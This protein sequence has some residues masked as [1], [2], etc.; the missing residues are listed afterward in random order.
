M[1]TKRIVEFVRKRDYVFIKELGQGGC[2][3]TVL[4]QDDVLDE[5]FVCKKYS[6]FYEQHKHELFDNFVREIKLLHEV[7]HQNVVRIFN[8]YLYPEKFTGYIVMEYIQGKDIEEY[9]EINPDRI[10]DVFLQTI[11]GFAHLEAKDI[12]HRD[13]R[14]MNILVRDDGVVKVIDLGFGKRV[15]Q[16]IDFDKSISLNWWCDPPDEFSTEIYDFRTEIYFV[17]KLFEKIIQE[18]K[19]GH[20]KYKKILGKMCQRSPEQRIDSFFDIEK[21]IQSNRFDEVSFYGQELNSY[22]EFANSITDHLTKIENGTKYIDDLEKI[23]SNLE[24]AYRCFML[25]TEAPD[26]VPILRCFLNGAYYYRKQG[27]S[28][29]VVEQFLSLLKSSDEEKQRIILA[30][31]HSRLDAITRYRERSLDDV[32]DDIPF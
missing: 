7:Y 8:Y 6:P 3:K 1:T 2:G 16:S 24:A 23:K 9:L 31:L 5:H 22:R 12:L 28:V 4:L 17:G 21:E 10:G 26:A 25:E 18:G 27:F 20:F 14:P 19:V 11:K 15:K 30:N 29:P 13:V 32:D